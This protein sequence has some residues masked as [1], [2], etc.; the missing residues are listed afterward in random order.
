MRI[1]LS[2]ARRIFTMEIQDD[3]RGITK[4]Q[5][6]H[7]SSIGLLGMREAVE[8]LGGTI[9]VT[10]QRGKGTQVVVRFPLRTPVRRKTR[11]ASGRAS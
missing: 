11:A 4:A 6:S 10:G 9:T 7:P 8:P 3:G 2:E 5:M 1:R